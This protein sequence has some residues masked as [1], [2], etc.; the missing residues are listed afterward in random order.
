MKCA[1]FSSLAIISLFVVAT[2][3][4]CKKTP[5]NPTP[6]HARGAVA[7]GSEQPKGPLTGPPVPE[8]P[9]SKIDTTTGGIPLSG[10]KKDWVPDP[11]QPDALRNNTVYFDFD[12]SEIKASEASKLDAIGSYMKG[13][14][15]RALRIEG[16]CD[17]RGTE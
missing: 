6:L 10:S 1:N 3:T 15:N 12:R 13:V 16:H 9:A 7:P 4:G 14:Q 17:E 2:G 8:D 11:N 5:Q